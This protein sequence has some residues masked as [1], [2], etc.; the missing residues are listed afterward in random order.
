MESSMSTESRGSSSASSKLSSHEFSIGSLRTFVLERVQH[1][2]QEGLIPLLASA[3]SSGQV[4]DLQD[5][6]DRFAFDSICSVVFGYNPNCLSKK[7]EE[8][9]RFFHALN[10]ATDLSI[11]RAMLPFSAI[12]KLKKL[13][14]IGSE[15]RLRESL[16][17]INKIIARFIT[18]KRVDNESAESRD[19]LSQFVK[20]GTQSNKS[21]RDMLISFLIAGRDTTPSALTWFFWILSS[22]PDIIDN[23]TEEIQSIRN[24]HKLGGSFTLDSLRDMNYLHAAISESLRLYPPVSLQARECR[25][26]DKFPDGTVVKKGWMVMYNTFAMGRT[27]KIWGEDCEEFRPERWL[28]DGVFRGRNPFEY[29]VFHAG[30]RMCLGK[31]MAFIQMKA[32]AASVLERFEM[33]VVEERGEHNVSMALRM[34][35]GLPVKFVERSR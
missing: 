18:S 6:L 23:I 28:V 17:I 25:S 15:R 20:D 11:G 16:K 30:P 4:L 12:W 2:I 21:L 13:F 22:R 5:V 33:E 34:G 19:F 24:P 3:S 10:E 8:G 31:D 14:N 7:D 1:E 27:E 9:N 26:D 29:P 32:V 35:G